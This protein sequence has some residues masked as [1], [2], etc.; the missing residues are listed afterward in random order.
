M[1]YENLIKQIE[2]NF[3][4]FKNQEIFGS[5]WISQFYIIN[6]SIKPNISFKM[7]ISRFSTSNISMT[8]NNFQLIMIKF[9][10]YYY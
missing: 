5:F 6:N 9:S 4:K 1:L 3:T 7:I 8:I 10:L 2:T